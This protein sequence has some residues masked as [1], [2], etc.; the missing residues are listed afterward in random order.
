V[1]ARLVRV[2][3][4]GGIASGKTHCLR[5]FERLGVP[6]ID[7][8]TLARDAVAPGTPG[9]AA[10]LRRFGPG[11]LQDDGTLDREALGRVVFN[12][13]TA[14]RD[15]EAVV[16]P[17]VYEGIHRWFD[18][19]A[20]RAADVP[21]FAV[22]EVPLLY[23]TGHAGDFDRVI[24]AACDRATQKRRAM[25]RDNASEADVERRLNA[26]LPIEDKARRADFVI[27]TGGSV[28]ATDRQI[29]AVWDE[30]R[31]PKEGSGAFLRGT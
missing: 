17:V 25:A 12:D 11:V 5:A 26:Q 4:T 27:D 23:E 31:A 28:E 22:A 10:V 13:P 21:A 6:V 7:A 2:A 18:G 30:L 1:A 19:L 3:L 8:D 14:R 20:G 24:V 29:V 15:L 16:H 9:L